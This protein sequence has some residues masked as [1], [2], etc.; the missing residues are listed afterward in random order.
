MTHIVQG[1]LY[2][3]IIKM[4]AAVQTTE[5]MNANPKAEVRDLLSMIFK[6]SI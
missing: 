5:C 3:K 4:L 2:F 1:N 6:M